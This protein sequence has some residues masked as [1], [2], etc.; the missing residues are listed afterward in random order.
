MEYTNRPRNISNNKL[1]LC[2]YDAAYTH[3]TEILLHIIKM[4]MPM[5]NRKKKEWY[6]GLPQQKSILNKTGVIVTE[7]DNNIGI[8]HCHTH[9]HV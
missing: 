9:A 5:C 8:E 2:A 1:H 4:L 7:F 3:T 6:A